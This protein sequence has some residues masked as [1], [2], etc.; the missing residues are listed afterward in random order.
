MR[1]HDACFFIKSTNIDYS[2]ITWLQNEMW[3]RLKS[4]GADVTHSIHVLTN[5][6]HNNHIM[7]IALSLLS[8]H[9]SHRVFDSTTILPNFLKP[10]LTALF[11]QK[12]SC[13]IVMKLWKGFFIIFTLHLQPTPHLIDKLFK[14]T[15]MLV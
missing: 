14:Q 11:S 3:T 4:N 6:W 5:K 9:G 2:G 12:Y 7:K 15:Y 13:N 10:F 8:R 1:L